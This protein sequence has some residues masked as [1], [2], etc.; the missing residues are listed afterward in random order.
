MDTSYIIL[1]VLF[2]L[3]LIVF[4]ALAIFAFA[5]RNKVFFCA[6]PRLAIDGDPNKLR[7]I[8]LDGFF[9]IISNDIWGKDIVFQT[10]AENMMFQYNLKPA[11]NATEIL[12]NKKPLIIEMYDSVKQ[13]RMSYVVRHSQKPQAI[14]FFS[15]YKELMD[16]INQHKMNGK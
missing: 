15:K 1:F 3:V 6:F 8:H 14:R 12:N 16:R 11:I 2:V 7:F 5:I 10:E 9:F 13:K 4:I